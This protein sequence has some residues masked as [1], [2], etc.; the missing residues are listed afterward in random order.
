MTSIASNS[1]LAQAAEQAAAAGTLTTAGTSSSA[2]AAAAASNTGTNALQSLAANFSQFLTLLTTQLQNQDPTAPMDTNSFTQE[3]VEFTGVQQS[4]ETNTNLASLISLQQGSEVLESANVIGHQAT[5][6]ANEIA[7]QNGSGSISFT[8]ASSEPIQIA[9]VDGNGLVI[10]D[11]S[12]T[13]Q[14]GSNS[15]QWDGTDNAG[16]SVPDGAYRIAVE[17]GTSSSNATAVPFSVVGTATGL[18]NSANGLILDIGALP[19][20]LTDVVAIAPGS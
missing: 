12:M 16:D 17:T 11:A 4:V 10:R 2:A 14:A 8:T 6:T 15:W 5:V 1:T 19:V 18:V 13:S 9:I 7:L 20:S 3:L